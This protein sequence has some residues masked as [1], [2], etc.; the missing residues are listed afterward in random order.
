MSNVY[1]RGIYHDSDVDN[2]LQENNTAVYGN[3]QY[4]QQNEGM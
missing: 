3:V 1:S 4:H 2:R